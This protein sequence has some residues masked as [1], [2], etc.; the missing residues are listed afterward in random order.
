MNPSE[1]P[2]PWRKPAPMPELVARTERLTVRFYL[3]EDAPQ[4]MEAVS[5]DRAALLPWLPWAATEHASPEAS[6]DNI[7]MFTR[8]RNQVESYD[9]TMALFETATGRLVGGTGFHRIDP[10]HATGE[11]GYWIRGTRQGEG[12]ATEAA[13]AVITTGFDDWGFRRIKLCCAATNAA[14][15]KVI[16]KLAFRLEAVEVA[17]RY[18]DGIGWSDSRTYACLTEEWDR[19]TG[20]GPGGNVARATS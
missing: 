5:E 13:R 15:I 14:S 17:E 10:T 1:R 12:F 18:V 8:L 6:R 3:P 4:L 16:E 9:F 19:A 2:A 20:R 11:V 7:H